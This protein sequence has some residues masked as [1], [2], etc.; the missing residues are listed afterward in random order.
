MRENIG[1]K[2]IASVAI[3]LLKESIEDIKMDDPDCMC[4]RCVR[5]RDW[6]DRA[7]SFIDKHQARK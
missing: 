7:Q 4:D 2:A 5:K 3:S 1:E 6:A